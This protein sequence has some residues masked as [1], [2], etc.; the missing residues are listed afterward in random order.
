MANRDTGWRPKEGL[1][2]YKGF[3]VWEYN[4]GPHQQTEGEVDGE[5]RIEDTDI[6]DVDENI[7]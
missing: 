1:S 4:V 3:E 6:E 5:V 2:T 7:R